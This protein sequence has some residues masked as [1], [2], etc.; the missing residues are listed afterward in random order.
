MNFSFGVITYNHEDLILELLESIKHQIH[1]YGRG[2]N[3]QLVVSDDASKD[4]TVEITK[5]WIGR[6]RELFCEVAV[7]ESETNTGTVEN[8]KRIMRHISYDHCKVI[9]GDDVFAD[10][11]VFQCLDGIDGNCL[12][13]YVPISLMHGEISLRTYWYGKHYMNMKKRRT[14]RYDVKKQ[15]VGSYFYT[16][17]TFY[18]KEL[19]TKYYE[20]HPTRFKLFEDD[21]FF[22]TVLLKNETSKVVFRNEYLVLYRIHENA[23]CSMKESPY[24]KLFDGELK[25]FKRQIIKEE[26]NIWVKVNLLLQIMPYR[27]RYLRLMFYI[28]RLALWRRR[29]VCRFDRD[30]HENYQKIVDRLEQT[31]IYYEGIKQ[32]AAALKK[33]FLATKGDQCY[34]GD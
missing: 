15:E 28:S 20:G 7:L 11:N 2:I 30:C 1:V 18:K 29:F 23:V 3:V 27:S 13:T 33:E 26:K 4:A 10:H 8:F 17:C 16:P 22:H 19:Y 31:K 32:N 25:E 24:K 14:H 9:A 12:V 6:N 21:P 5:K 34:A